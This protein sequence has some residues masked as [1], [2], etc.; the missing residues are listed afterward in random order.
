MI[1][2]NKRSLSDIK[3][4]FNNL[5]P[6]LKIEFYRVEHGPEQGSKRGDQYDPDMMIG[7]IRT[8]DNEGK[9]EMDSS[10]TVAELEKKFED[11]YDLHVQIFRRSGKLW[12]QTT[13][14][15]EWTLEVQNRKG[16]H[17]MEAIKE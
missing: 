10:M 17:S 1:I 6:G 5:F 9:M 3:I 14:T 16:I 8:W 2:N 11:E 12:L 4:E 15:D 13:T 7:D